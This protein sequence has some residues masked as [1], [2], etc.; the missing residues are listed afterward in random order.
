MGCIQDGAEK[1]EDDKLEANSQ[2][3]LRLFDFNEVVI[4]IIGK[5]SVFLLFICALPGSMI[6]SEINLFTPLCV[7]LYLQSLKPQS[8]ICPAFF[9][10]SW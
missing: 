9:V 6:F 1:H 8:S 7:E 10:T 3:K 2:S 5:R 4:R